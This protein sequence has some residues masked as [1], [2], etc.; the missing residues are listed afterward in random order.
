MFVMCSRLRDRALRNATEAAMGDVTDAMQTALSELD[1]ISS[2][3]GLSFD[4]TAEVLG[5]SPTTLR[6][7]RRRGVPPARAAVISKLFRATIILGQYVRSDR[8]P[9]VVR[10]SAV[11][12][13]G[14]SLMQLARAGQYEKLLTSMGRVFDLRR[15]AP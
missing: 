7:Y 10:R 11:I 14:K 15:V 5:V 8:I 6:R 2:A 3:W 9:T 13:G 4:E 1:A 12:L